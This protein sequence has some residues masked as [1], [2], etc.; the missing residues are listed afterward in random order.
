MDWRPVLAVALILVALPSSA[1]GTE[2]IAK[3]GEYR[4]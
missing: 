3:S 1:K 2:F 4:C